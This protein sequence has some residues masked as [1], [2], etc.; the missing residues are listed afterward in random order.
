[1]EEGWS[2]GVMLTIECPEHSPCSIKGG[3]GQVVVSL[4]D[5]PAE[6]EAPAL[7]IAFSPFL[8]VWSHI[9]LSHPKLKSCL[10]FLSPNPWVF[11]G[12]HPAPVAGTALLGDS[13]VTAAWLCHLLTL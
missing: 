10:S 3:R 13:G 7:A 12:P 2:Q 11:Q 1:M 8:C 6:P 4:T 9:L 5:G